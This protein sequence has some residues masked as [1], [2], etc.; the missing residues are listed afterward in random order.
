MS[1]AWEA[2]LTALVEIAGVWQVAGVSSASMD[3]RPGQYG[4]TDVYTR[5]S[6]YVEWID[7]VM[8]GRQPPP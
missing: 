1:R 3:G 4:V 8:A 6:S 5:V 7:A 2:G